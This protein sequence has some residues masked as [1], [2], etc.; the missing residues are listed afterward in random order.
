[1]TNDIDELFGILL[2]PAI[3][4][5]I[6]DNYKLVINKGARDKIKLG[7]RFLIYHLEKEPIVDPITKESLGKLEIVR[8]TGKVIYIQ[9]KMSIIE[10]DSKR[11]SFMAG[12]FPTTD[13]IIPFDGAKI[14]D[15]AKP[16]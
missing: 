2:K 1:M 13:N 8:G 15:K 10:S 5:K 12:L 4:V 16:I 6:I 14:G 11:Q 9:E 3:V 7:Q